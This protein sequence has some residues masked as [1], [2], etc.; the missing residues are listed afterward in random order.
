MQIA[1]AKV[2]IRL[3]DA[4]TGHVYF[5]AIGAGEASTESGQ[6]AG[7][8]SKA[9]YDATLNDRVI[10]AAISDVID[11]L[12]SRLED[13]PWKTDILQ[14]QDGQVFISGGKRQGLKP[15]DVLSVMQP[16][17]TIKSAQSGF[18]VNLP[19]KQVATV[20]ILSLFGDSETDEGCVCEVTS[21]SIAAPGGKKLFVTESKGGAL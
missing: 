18:D 20:R 5:S 11:K 10:A 8:G 2:D 12:V 6:I 15:G 7:Y 13:R 14:V 1:K 4:K 16:G 19:P 17:N 9:E 3:V 21:G